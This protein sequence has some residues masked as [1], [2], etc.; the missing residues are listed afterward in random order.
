MS[1]AVYF[2]SSWKMSSSLTVHGTG[3]GIYPLHQSWTS[4]EQGNEY[5]AG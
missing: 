3:P 4:R 5:N 2:G 1:I